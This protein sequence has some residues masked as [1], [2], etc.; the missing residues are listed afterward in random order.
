MSPPAKSQKLYTDSNLQDTILQHTLKH[1]TSTRKTRVSPKGWYSGNAP[2]CQHNGETKDT[3]G[4]GGIRPNEDGSFTYHCFNCHYKAGYAPGRP[5]SHKLRNLL[6]WLGAGENDIN[7]LVIEALRLRDLTDFI[8]AAPKELEELEFKERDLPKG[9]KSFTE[10]A[11]GDE[12]PDGLLSAINYAAERLGD[13]TEYPDIYWTTDKAEAMNKRIIF[14]FTWQNKVV[15]YSGRTF[16]KIIK[17]K[18]MVAVDSDYVYG[19]DHLVKESEFV[20]V[21]EGVIDA[22][23]L[24]G[25]AV[26]SNKIS[27]EQADQIE[28]L[29]KQV[30]VVPDLNETGKPLIDS[31]IEYD[32]HVAFPDWDDD[33]K[34][35]GEAVQRYGKLFT[36]KSI[37][38]NVAT[39][40]TKIELLKRRIH[41]S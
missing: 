24:N 39:N 19:L 32:W 23:L 34:D 11:D 21:F 7:Y 9:A 4:R 17:P 27:V 28:Q 13:L 6:R 36:L 35:A 18:Y 31:A 37:I 29:G 30:I 40:A 3:R 25:V 22:L 5:L 16:K 1:W 8:V 15:G 38:S 26:L 2:C 20:L 12:Y 10:W 41:G 33:V 14:P